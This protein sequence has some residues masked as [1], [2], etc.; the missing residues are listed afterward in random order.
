MAKRKADT[1]SKP[2]RRSKRLQDAKEKEKEKKRAEEV[3]ITD[4]ISSDGGLT[5]DN[6][7]I[8]TIPTGVYHHPTH[9]TLVQ[10]NMGPVILLAS[11]LSTRHT[12]NGPI[13]LPVSDGGLVSDKTIL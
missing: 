5:Y 6:I 7:I 12:G 1:C 8:P 13:N 3:K 10:T 9:N 4:Y 11:S 2:S